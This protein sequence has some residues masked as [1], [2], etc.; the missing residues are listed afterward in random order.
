MDGAKLPEIDG[1]RAIQNMVLAAWDL[2]IGTCWITN[3]YEDGVKEILAAP[4]R[5]KLI[6]VMPFGYPV[7]TQ[8]KRKK[9]RKSMSEIVHFEKFG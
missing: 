7:T 5:M 4:Q 3:F 9:N 6:T 1:T 2:G 8:V